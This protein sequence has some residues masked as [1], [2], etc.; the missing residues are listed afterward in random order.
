M[1][2]SQA[3]EHWRKIAKTQTTERYTVKR[4]NSNALHEKIKE[5]E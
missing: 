1:K 3:N 2:E 4:K 5:I